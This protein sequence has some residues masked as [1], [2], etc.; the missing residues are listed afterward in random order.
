MSNQ[1]DENEQVDQVDVVE[2]DQVDPVDEASEPVQKALK[3][4]GKVVWAAC[5]A[6]PGCE[7]NF[8]ELVSNSSSPLNAAIISSSGSKR[9]RY[10]CTKCR[11]SWHVV[12]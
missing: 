11:R 2:N 5:R 7:G 4:Q 9:V 3:P 8:A 10:R 1:V 12:Y 6:T